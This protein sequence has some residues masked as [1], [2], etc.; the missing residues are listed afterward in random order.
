[1]ANYDI[2]GNILI[3]KFNNSESKK[4]K[5]EKARQ[6][7]EQNKN[8]KSIFE[9]SE[10]IKGRLRIPKLS[11]LIGDKTTQ[12]IHKEN[13]CSFKLDLSKCYF[14]PRMS[15]DR[16]K[17]SNLVKK[18]K[19]KKV[20]V[21]FAG[22]GPYPIVLAKQN[23]CQVTAIELGKDC[24]NYAKTN[25]ILNKV[26]DRVKI[27]A[28]D[29]KKIIPKLKKQ[30]EIFDF[31]VMAR[32]NLKDNFLKEALSVAKKGTLIYYHGFWRES[33]KDKELKK[34]L[35]VNKKI[36]LLDI[37]EIGDIAPYEHRY[38]LLLRFN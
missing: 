18:Y 6:L 28:G 12:T 23:N 34:L 19:P 31:I 29:V 5:L 21:M 11:H 22:I 2:I 20:L 24:C 15:N 3:I 16:I 13:G 10:K 17:V 32:P 33:E 36:K 14:S 37:Q 9:K 35:S 25:T 7:L 30:K 1:M 4:Q 27:L 8:I 38:G 26:E